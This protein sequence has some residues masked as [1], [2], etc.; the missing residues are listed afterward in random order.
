MFQTELNIIKN[1]IF[2]ILHLFII[3][4]FDKEYLTKHIKYYY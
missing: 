1:K 2:L 3:G 4:K